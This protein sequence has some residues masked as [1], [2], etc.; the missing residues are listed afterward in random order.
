MRDEWSDGFRKRLLA[1]MGLRKI[2]PAEVARRIG[3]VESTVSSWAVGRSTPNSRWVV[4]LCRALDV[5]VE[6][7][8]GGGR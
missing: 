2:G 8:F 3:S 1:A 4:P 6:W 7:L 5:P